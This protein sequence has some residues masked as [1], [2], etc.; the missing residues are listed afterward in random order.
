[1]RIKLTHT[2][3]ES[4]RERPKNTKRRTQS[5]AET[6]QNAI[7]E[8]TTMYAAS[9]SRRRASQWGTKPKSTLTNTM[10]R[11]SPCDRKRVQSC[12]CD[13]T[14]K[15]ISA[16]S[17]HDYALLATS[18]P[19]RTL[20]NMSLPEAWRELGATSCRDRRECP[21][22]ESR[23]AFTSAPVGQRNAHNARRCSTTAPSG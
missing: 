16:T 12:C 19:S 6:P 14:H 10:D 23:R 13:Q 11:V 17:T 18:P 2:T 15:L 20:N 7:A 1:M 9:A 3:T 22:I 8:N 5:Q 21:W 4:R